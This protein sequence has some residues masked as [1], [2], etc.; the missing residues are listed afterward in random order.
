MPKAGLVATRLP[1]GDGVFMHDV[2]ILY[3]RDGGSNWGLPPSLQ[4]LGNGIE[5]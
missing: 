5:V 1:M 2:H 4:E 3:V